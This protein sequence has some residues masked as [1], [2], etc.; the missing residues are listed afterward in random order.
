MSLENKFQADLIDDLEDLFPDAIITK[1]DAN[2][3]QG[4]PDLLILKGKK[5]A[6]LECKRSETAP[7]RPN[8]EYYVEK[9]NN[10]SFAAVIYPENKKE[11]LDELQS[12]LRSGR[13]ARVPRSK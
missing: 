5:W 8:Q 1:L 6:V 11:V 9:M 10:M 12:A 7:F 4:I 3:I 13:H 2:H